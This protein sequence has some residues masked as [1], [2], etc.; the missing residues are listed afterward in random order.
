M[1]PQ[2]GPQAPQAPLLPVVKDV[3]PSQFLAN[4]KRRVPFQRGGRSSCLPRSI[5]D[6][7]AP[8]DRGPP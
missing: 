7:A 4:A 8:S 3:D 6:G 5:R 1:I 2:Q